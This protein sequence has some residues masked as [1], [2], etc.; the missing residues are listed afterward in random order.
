VEHGRANG[1]IN[2][3]V[4]AEQGFALVPKKTRVYWGAPRKI[5]V[6]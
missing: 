5:G 2:K 6:E 3:N 4:T 1:V